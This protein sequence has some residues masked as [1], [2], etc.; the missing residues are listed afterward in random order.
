MAGL[1]E[2]GNEPPGSLKA[3]SVNRGTMEPVDLVSVSQQHH[4]RVCGSSSG[5]ISTGISSAG[6]DSVMAPCRYMVSRETLR[7]YATRRSETNTNGT[8][9]DSNVEKERSALENVPPNLYESVCVPDL[10]EFLGG[11][12]SLADQKVATTGSSSGAHPP[13]AVTPTPASNPSGYLHDD[14]EHKKFTLESCSG[15]KKTII[16]RLRDFGPNRAVQWEIRIT[17]Y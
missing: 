7:R 6:G 17:A 13:S 12:H 14:I 15:V 10:S 1:C 2:G 8:E 3:I 16:S 9:F 5:M 4:C 11:Y